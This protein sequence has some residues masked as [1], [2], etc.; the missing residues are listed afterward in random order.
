MENNAGMGVFTEKFHP[1]KVLLVGT[2]GIPYDEFLKIF[3][4]WLWQRF[5]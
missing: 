3:R 5:R 2:G 4:L 1:A